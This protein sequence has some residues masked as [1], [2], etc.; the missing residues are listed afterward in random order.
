MFV[1]IINQ[2]FKE[3]KQHQWFFFTRGKNVTIINQLF[4]ELKPQ[5]TQTNTQAN[6]VTIINQLFKELKHKIHF[7][8]AQISGLQL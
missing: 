3:L 1:T 5:T 6:N 2:L 7:L 4:K 8:I